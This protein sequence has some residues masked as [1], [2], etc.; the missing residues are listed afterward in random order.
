MKCGWYM[1]DFLYIFHITQICF[2][3]ESYFSLHKTHD[4]Q[5]QS[6]GNLVVGHHNL[7]AAG[8][9]MPLAAD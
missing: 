5:Q 1:I 7:I 2:W 9:G 4:I 8:R 6:G 3:M